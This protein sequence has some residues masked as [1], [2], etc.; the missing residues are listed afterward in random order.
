MPQFLTLPIEQVTCMETLLSTS[1]FDEIQPCEVQVI[2][3]EEIGE[4]VQLVSAHETEQRRGE[5]PERARVYG[6]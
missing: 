1:Q 2:F 4:D 3:A 5:D 6:T